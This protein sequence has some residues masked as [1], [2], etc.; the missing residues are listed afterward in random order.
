[1]LSNNKSRDDVASDAAYAKLFN[2]AGAASV[3]ERIKMAQAYE[4]QTNVK[5]SKGLSDHDVFE[6]AHD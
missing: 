6:V 5:T 2:E 3:A 1:M 4:E